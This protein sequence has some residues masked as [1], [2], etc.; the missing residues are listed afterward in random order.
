[1]VF[2]YKQYDG[3]GL[4]DLIKKNEVKLEEVRSMAILEIENKNPKLNAIIHKMYD[5]SQ[6]NLT[7]VFAGVPIL[8]KNIAQ[9]SKGQ[10]MT[11]GS[12]ALAEYKADH[13]SEFV[14]QIMTTG[15]NILGQTNVPEFALMGI[16]EP[17]FYG[18][19]RNPWNTDYTPGGSSGGSAAAVASGMVPIAGANDGGGS[20]RIPAAYCGLFG[21]K[22]TRGRTPI[23]PARGRSW[24]GASVDHILTRS[25]RDSAAMLDEYTPDRANAFI[26]PTFEGSYLKASQT[27]INRPLN[28]AFTTRS[29]LG[30]P[31]D[32]ECK[33]AVH[34]TLKLLESMGHHVEE[35]EAPIDGKR[36]AESY[37]MMYFAEVG[38]TLR[39]IEKKVSRKVTSK[40]VE[41]TTWILGLL[42]KAV[43]AKDFLTS[44]KYWDEVAI[45]MEDFHENY[46]FYITPTTAFP[47]SK[48][49]KLDQTNAEKI[50]IKLVSSFR[51]NEF[52]N[53]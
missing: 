8:T 48:I 14:R 27:P 52:H 31:V 12:K 25:V 29:P 42:G 3:L 13:D 18:P 20:I 11:M 32:E 33:V 35:K 49:G 34:K 23:G 53:F 19:S 38:S 10:P 2:D 15:V 22:P 9:E 45:K 5:E 36:L 46:D 1:M 24:Q 21:L 39:E 4:A 7:G 50:L 28:I 44:L 30:T 41:P 16:T 17:T 43:T 26:A 6:P 40:D 51:L 47:P 37:L